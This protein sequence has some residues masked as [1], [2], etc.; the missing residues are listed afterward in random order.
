MKMRMKIIVLLFVIFLIIPVVLAQSV[1]VSVSTSQKV[2]EQEQKVSVKVSLLDS[3][4]NPFN[5]NVK[6]ILEDAKKI[7]S[8]EKEISSNNFVDIDL[9]E[10]SM[11]GDWFV[12]AIY[13]E[14]KSTTQFILKENQLAK[15]DLEGDKLI[16]TNI[17]N[18]RYVKNIRI[19]IGNTRSDKDVDLAV[20]K[21]LTYRLIA[22]DGVYNL[23]I[24]DDNGETIISRSNVELTGRVIG[25]L[26]ESAS[27]S[28]G[29]TGGIKLEDEWG[30]FSSFKR[31]M[32]VYIFVLAI[33]GAMI[34]LVIERQ[35]KKKAR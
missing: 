18:V 3:N 31:N 17:G 33:F 2:Y 34:L 20:G 35:Y 5:D 7:T 11:P 6:V 1:K 10:N 14:S 8:I 23:E 19:I 22:P 16:I 26:D 27:R 13:K 24:T 4:N 29:I 21:S 28:S 12:T 25:I 9:G 15:F 30:I 32:F